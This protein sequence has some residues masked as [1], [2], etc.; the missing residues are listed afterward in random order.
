MV[1]RGWRGGAEDAIAG[2]IA[3]VGGVGRQP[4]N[5]TLWHWSSAAVGWAEQPPDY[6][7]WWLG[8]VAPALVPVGFDRPS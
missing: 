4:Q 5:L 1:R 2:Q 3:V 6:S 7:S 8:A